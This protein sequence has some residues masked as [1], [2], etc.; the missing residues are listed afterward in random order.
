MEILVLLS[1]SHRVIL[2]IGHMVQLILHTV[3]L[4]N[5]VI[6]VK[7]YIC[8]SKTFSRRLVFS[9]RWIWIFV[10]RRSN[11]SKR[12]RDFSRWI[13]FV[14]IHRRKSL[15]LNRPVNFIYQKL[16]CFSFFYISSVISMNFAI[17]C[18]IVM[19]KFTFEMKHTLLSWKGCLDF[20]KSII[21]PQFEHP[22][23]Q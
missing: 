21:S 11:Y 16:F 8:F 6:L 18:I 17:H 9:F 4:L 19:H 14:E 23:C 15:C 1:T 5:F 3:M 2:P 13:S 12:S 20:N 22:K 7:K 10:T